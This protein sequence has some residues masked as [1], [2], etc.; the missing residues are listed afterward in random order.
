MLLL[1]PA[2][3]N[4]LISHEPRVPAWQYCPDHDHDI[5][6]PWLSSY[7]YIL[8][9]VAYHSHLKP[10]MATSQQPVSQSI[11]TAT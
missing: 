10:I 5:M 6:M 3:R 1:M 9:G 11:V 4:A 8:S 2:V 7:Y